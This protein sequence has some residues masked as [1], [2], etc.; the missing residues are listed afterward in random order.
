MILVH[1]CIIVPDAYAPMAGALTS[2]ATPA[3]AGMFIQGL[4][5]DGTVTHRFSNGL[6]SSEFS[7]ILPLDE[8]DEDSQQYVRTLPGDVAAI[9]AISEGA[10]TEEQV[11]ALL[12]AAVCTADQWSVAAA[13]LGLTLIPSDKEV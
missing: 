12:D 2:I 6:I 9:V 10:A 4:G 3:G 13:R 7:S 11:Q 5:T 8:W 1:R